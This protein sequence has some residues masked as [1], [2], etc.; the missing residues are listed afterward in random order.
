MYDHLPQKTHPPC[1]ISMKDDSPKVKFS[2]WNI[3]T[4]RISSCQ[5]TRGIVQLFR[6]LGTSLSL[7]RSQFSLQ[8][9]SSLPASAIQSKAEEQCSKLYSF[10]L[11]CSLMQLKCGSFPAHNPSAAL[12]WLLVAPPKPKRIH[13]FLGQSFPPGKDEVCPPGCCYHP[14]EYHRQVYQ[15]GA[16]VTARRGAGGEARRMNHSP[17]MRDPR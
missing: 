11:I 17:N 1:V 3:I 10:F 13:Y 8:P 15:H 4:A 16:V 6:Q 12:R 5:P 9:W 14:Q 7:R 2:P